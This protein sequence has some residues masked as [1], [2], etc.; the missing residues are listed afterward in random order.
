M[1][2]CIVATVQYVGLHI[3]VYGTADG[4]LPVAFLYWGL[5][6]WPGH[7]LALVKCLLEH[8]ADVNAADKGGKTPL[9]LASNR[10]DLAEVK[11]LLDRGAYLHARTRGDMSVL[12]FARECEP[13][14]S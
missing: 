13:V 9:H 4:T 7:H 14:Y 10:G 5:P 11:L 2:L 12:D 3:R 8:G 6:T 1:Q